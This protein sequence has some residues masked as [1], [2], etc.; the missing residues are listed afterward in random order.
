MDQQF[1]YA[2]P[3]SSSTSNV[4]NK[5]SL[6]YSHCS[7]VL[8]NWLYASSKIS[9]PHFKNVSNALKK[10]K[11][12]YPLARRKGFTFY[13]VVLVV[14]VLVVDRTAISQIKAF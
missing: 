7:C 5:G 4:F 1:Y 2:S 10:N 9:T 12:F 8:E 6:F 13:F 11:A 3:F 14:L